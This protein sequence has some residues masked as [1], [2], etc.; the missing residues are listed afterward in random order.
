MLEKSR[1]MSLLIGK[2][3]RVLTHP[4]YHGCISKWW[5]HVCVFVALNTGDKSCNII[6]AYLSHK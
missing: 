6:A 2:T 1:A 5:P 4:S 3:Q